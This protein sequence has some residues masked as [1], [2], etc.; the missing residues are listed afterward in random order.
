M[1]NI[2]LSNKR[3]NTLNLIEISNEV[4]NTEAAIYSLNYKGKKL[5]FKNL[6]KL[7]GAIFANKLYTI[8]MLSNNE[9]YLPSSFVIPQALCS[10]NG[11]IMGFIDE[12]IEGEN[13]QVILNN[14][15]VDMNTKLYYLQQIGNI[16]EQLQYIRSI[17]DIDD[18]YINDLHAGNIIVTPSRELKIIDLDSCKICENRP[19]PSKYLTGINSLFNYSSKYKIFPKNQKQEYISEFGYISADENSD[20]YCYIITIMNFLYGD[21]V[22]NMTMD[23]FYK[24]LNY[25]ESIGI[26]S[27]LID[28]FEKIILNCDNKNPRHKISDLKNMYTQVAKANKKVYKLVA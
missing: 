15:K 9:K 7:S 16:L 23:E 12:Y 4:T 24:Y 13:L 10:V 26:P 20:L 6:Y 2:N 18:I 3:F 21:N 28:D 17:D 5:V 14:P 19:F 1:K 25:I 11:N 22:N 27:D 8:E